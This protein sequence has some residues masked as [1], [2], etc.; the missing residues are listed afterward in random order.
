MILGFSHIV[1]SCTDITAACSRFKKAGFEIQFVEE[2]IPNPPEKLGFLHT[3]SDRQS[4]AFAK[5]QTGPGVE[6][7][8]HPGSSLE[9]VGAYGA[10][11]ASADQNWPLLA[12]DTGHELR[13]TLNSD[14]SW[15]PAHIETARFNAWTLPKSTTSGVA[16]VLVNCL[17]L[18]ASYH[19]WTKGVGAKPTP[20]NAPSSP[21]LRFT[22][23]VPAWS[24]DLLLI[25]DAHLGSDAHAIDDAGFN[26][27][28]LVSNNIKADRDRLLSLGAT[29][30][31]DPFTLQVNGKTL[32]LSLLRGPSGEPLELLSLT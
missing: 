5:G 1:L 16:C 14:E 9:H 19:F 29:A 24:I 20:S 12:E 6:L 25:A 32:Q 10:C 22:S 17:D 13:Y 23:P 8:H 7:I 26:C 4:L 30:A 28:S 31:T 27:V 2:N 11:I 3:L 18:D 15:R 21:H